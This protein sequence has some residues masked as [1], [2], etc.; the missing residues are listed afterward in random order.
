VEHQAARSRKPRV[1]VVS[2]FLDKS[3]G[4]ERMVIEWLERLSDAFE[5]HVYSQHVEDLDLAKITWHRVPTLPGPHLFNFLYW[6]GANRR[7]RA[8]DS[9][10]GS[11]PFDIVFSPGTNCTDAD[12]VTVH[13]VFAEFVRRLQPELKFARKPIRFW[14]RLAHRRIY[15]RTV[16]SLERRV[17]QNPRTQLILTA[18]QTAEEIARFFQRHEKF[19][20]VSAGLDHS[21]FNPERRAQLRAKARESLKIADDR[22]ALLLVGNDWR[23]KGLGTLIL[24]LEAL[25]DLPI[26]LFA[27]G[28]DDPSA[29]VA[30]VPGTLRGRLRFL[31]PR[32]DVEFYY[33]AADAYTGPSLEDTFALPASEAMACG[34]PVIISARAGAAALVTHGSDGLI[35]SDPTDAK[36]LAALIRRLYEDREL[37][38]RLG[39]NA[40]LT[41]QK[42]TWE[43]SASDLAAVFNEILRRRGKH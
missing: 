17:F 19:P 29:L 21:V 41:A 30:L 4:T 22:F 7:R 34:L 32:K 38:E 15:Y 20:V 10:K 16:M 1:A 40:V 26:D 3:H 6:F 27:A 42:Y 8:R 12:A 23:K 39:K 9:R 24:A 31:P 37:R 33:A 18:P 25:S 36:Q 28:R 13:I 35:L 5:F 11:L 2:P 43:Q 14:L